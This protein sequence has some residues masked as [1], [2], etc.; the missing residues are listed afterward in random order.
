MKKLGRIPACLFNAGILLNLLLLC[1]C[2]TAPSARRPL[3]PDVSINPDAHRSLPADVPIN[4]DAGRG[5]LL[6][7]TVQLENGQKL[8][9]IVDTG[10]G[11]TCFDKS[12]KPKLE[13]PLGTVTMH[14]M[15]GIS[16]NNIYTA[17]K[18][19]LGGAP[20]L[21]TG[22]AIAT[23]DVN[24]PLSAFA[25]RRVMGILGIDVLENYCIQLDFD[26]GK[27]RFLDDQHADKSTWGK[28]FPIVSLNDQDPRP[29]VAENLLGLQGPHSLIDSGFLG[30][31]SLM[32]GHFQLWTNSAV[33]PTN[34][35]ARLPDGV[36]GG[37]K[38][39][40]VFLAEKDW[41]SDAIGL[42][43][44]ARHLVTF[45]FPNHTM[46]LQRQSIG[47]LSNLKLAQLKPIPDREPKVTAHL[48]A[49]MQD[50]IDGTEHP[51]DYT[52]SGWKYLLSNQKDIQATT[53]LAGDIVSLTLVERSSVFGWQRSYCYRVEFTRATMLV[54]FVFHGRNKLAS[55]HAEAVEW[56]VRPTIPRSDAS[57]EIST[58]GL[59]LTKN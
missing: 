37:E 17:P 32:P 58:F 9:F 50:L 19:Y 21:M 26:T 36:F 14:S 16:T 1:S 22:S 42:N 49:V 46:Y 59:Y 31:G 41:P 55:G 25:G 39:P 56:K 23:W 45:D 12:L 20:L 6:V 10:A 8:P 43:F 51:D 2:A 53:K 30:D 47:P 44:L 29:A 52:A 11:W 7:V 54:H 24:K 18:L 57:S 15:F 13:K 38:Y 33:V 34:G 4:Q 3:P 27:M 28:A 5:G 40:L 35:E 48:R